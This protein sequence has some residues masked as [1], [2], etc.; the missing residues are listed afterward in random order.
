MNKLNIVSA[1]VIQ[2]ALIVWLFA[3]ESASGLP[4]LACMAYLLWLRKVSLQAKLASSVVVCLV[5]SSLFTAPLFAVVS[6]FSLCSLVMEEFG[7]HVTQSLRLHLVMTVVLGLG[8]GFVVGYEWTYL[9][10]G[11]LVG[12]LFT[13]GVVTVW[14]RARQSVWT[15]NTRLKL[16]V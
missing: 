5:L 8:I 7:Y 12:K 16:G 14:W 9:A 15:K 4:W 10:I 11:L 2:L 3:L 6:V 13:V 1:P